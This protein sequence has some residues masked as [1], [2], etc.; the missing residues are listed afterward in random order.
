M[1]AELSLSSVSAMNGISWPLIFLQASNPDQLT[2]PKVLPIGAVLFQLLFLFVAIPIE[3]YILHVRLKF[4]KKTSAFYSIAMNVFSSV[5]G[6]LIFFIFEPVLPV[7]E[8]KAEIINYIFFNRFKSRDIQSWIILTSFTIFFTTF[9]MKLF[10]LK[11]LMIALD[12]GGKQVEETAN[13]YRQVKLISEQAKIQN[14]TLVT[15]TLIAN[16]LTYSAITIIMLI[17]NR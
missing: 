12:E 1:L 10:L 15:T 11:F 14:T 8:V 9:L 3:A 4:D 17:R 7:K 6:W 13:P 16:S 5:L 2:I